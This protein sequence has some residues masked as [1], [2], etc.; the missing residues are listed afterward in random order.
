MLAYLIWA[1]RGWPMIHDAPL[2]HY[3]AWLIDQGGVPYRD[4]FDM[5]LPGAYLIHLVV[6]RV[7]G[8]GDAAWRLFDLGWLAA[9]CVVLVAYCRRISHGW[10][11]AGA[12]LLFALYHLSGGAWHAGQRDFVLCF[13]LLLGAWGIARGTE[14][15][16]LA[17]LVWGGL[18]LGAAMTIKPHAALYWIFC[19][20][21]AARDRS[22]TVSPWRA[23]ALVI[24]AG[25]VVPAA[26][27]GWLAWR[28]GLGPFVDV[29]GGYVVPLYSGVGRVSPW[30]AIVWH[31]Y[32]RP[33]VA[34]FGLLVVLALLG[35]TSRE[36]A[37]K[38]LALVGVVYGI[39]HFVVQGKGWEYQL[40]PLIVFCCALVPA[41]VVSWRRFGWARALDLFGARRPLALAAWTLLVVVLSVKGVEASDAGWIAEK[42]RRVA[43]ITRDLEP[44]AP[45]GATVQ[46]MDTT[47][48]GIHSL[49]RLHLRQP[50]RFI[51]DFYFFHDVGDRR[52]EALRAEFLSG[53][54]SGRPAAL[55]ILEESWPVPGYGR[56]ES[57]PR[58]REYLERA[59]EPPLERPGYRIYAKRR[60]S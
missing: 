10:A 49:L 25:L 48:G 18:V 21:I 9:T 39:V 34:L 17:S 43:D 26:V 41:A 15:G 28:G 20:V 36:P 23:A 22:W 38:G 57:F 5:N 2:I 40:Y 45:P 7:G 31:A 52:I 53:L 19:A 3:I 32:G 51:Y 16:A 4:A 59:Y 13:F 55:V 8:A 27:F 33:L 29:F 37:R 1:S 24:A 47:S 44:L 6:L 58:L 30:Q 54:E 50:T 35:P 14:Q 60:D 46:V 12:A 11:A 56:L 42:T